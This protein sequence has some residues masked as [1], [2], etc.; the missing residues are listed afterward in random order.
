MTRLPTDFVLEVHAA[1]QTIDITGDLAGDEVAWVAAAV[2][3]LAERSPHC[4]TI[5]GSGVDDVDAT[6]LDDLATLAE[7]ALRNGTRVEIS[8]PSPAFRKK[9]ISGGC[10][11]L[12]ARSAAR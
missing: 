8:N 4:I 2:N 10:A 12:L 11:F 6:G 9:L 1:T 3:Q 5:D 7:Q